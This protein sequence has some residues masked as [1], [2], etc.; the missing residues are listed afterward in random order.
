MLID[1]TS[2]TQRNIGHS[3]G[4]CLQTDPGWT[5][6]HLAQGPHMLLIKHFSNTV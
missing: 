1:V 3:P 5:E 2:I 6:I 4:S